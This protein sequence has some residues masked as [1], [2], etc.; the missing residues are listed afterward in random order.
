MHG[1][2][3]WPLSSTPDQPRCLRRL[4]ISC[5][6]PNHPLIW[7]SPQSTRCSRQRKPEQ[8]QVAV[9]FSVLGLGEWLVS[10]NRQWYC[11]D[12]RMIEMHNIRDVG[13]DNEDNEAAEN[14]LL[15][16]G[17]RNSGFSG[18]WSPRSSTY[19]R[20]NRWLCTRVVCSK[21]SSRGWMCC[22]VLS[23][24]IMSSLTTRTVRYSVSRQSHSKYSWR[25][26]RWDGA[27][28]FNE[29]HGS[30]YLQDGRWSRED[31]DRASVTGKCILRAAAECC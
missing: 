18:H 11:Q 10:I 7:R 26:G 22:S 21:H 25:V 31:S 6:P 19:Y 17:S 15:P 4:T 14:C 3:H 12:D 16:W 2:R 13:D 8:P 30:Q 20:S 5:D 9:V 29:H 27:I 23:K 24:M 1:R 28:V